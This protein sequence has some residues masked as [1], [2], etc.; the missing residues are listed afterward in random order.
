MIFSYVY[1][2]C[3]IYSFIFNKKRS[4]DY[5]VEST[6]EAARKKCREKHSTTSRVSLHFLSVL[7]AF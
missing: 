1:L 3:S 5:A 2:D 7:A 6:Q 4:L